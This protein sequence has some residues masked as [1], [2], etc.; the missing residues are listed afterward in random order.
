MARSKRPDPEVQDLHGFQ[1]FKRVEKLFAR[2]A[3]VGTKRDRAGNRKLTFDRYAMLLLLYFFSPALTSLRDLHAAS[4]LEKVRRALGIRSRAYGSLSEAAEVFDAQL[5]EPIIQELFSQLPQAKLASEHEALRALTAVDGSL[6]PALPRMAWALWQNDTHRAA[7]LHL[8]FEVFRGAPVD[9]EVTPANCSEA[10]T[11]RQLLEPNRLYVLDRGYREYAT[12]QA[13]LDANSSFIA[14]VCSN[15]AV[16]KVIEERS[17]DEAARAQGILRDRVVWLGCASK[18]SE[19][20]RPLRLIEV[21]TEAD[22]PG[23]EP[24]VMLLVTDRLDLE[25]TLVALGYRYRWSVELFFRWLKSILGCRHLLSESQNGV[26]IQVYMALIASLLLSLWS[27]TPPNKATYNMIN[28]YLMGW[29][30]EDEVIAHFE[31]QR[32]KATKQRQQ[33][34]AIP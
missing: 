29:A 18:R 4:N 10:H 16:S 34:G 30:S 6:L 25:P 13:I 33:A 15:T 12:L 26:T 11:L 21:Q 24:G 19:F 1:L 3:K 22:Q 5:L 23:G 27:G 7:K 2:L 14:R 17:L 8:S 9:A 28:F 31:A 32:A 20:D